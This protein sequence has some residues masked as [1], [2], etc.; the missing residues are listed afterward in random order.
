MWISEYFFLF[1]S[2]WL[3]SQTCKYVLKLL[4]LKSFRAKDLYHTYVYASGM[5]STHAAVLSSSL[6]FLG[7]TLGLDNPI[8]F[9]FAAFGIFWLYEIHLQRERFK[10]IARLLPKAK[11][12]DLALLRD[13]QGHDLS[14][15]IGGV[16]LGTLIYFFPSR[17][18]LA[19]GI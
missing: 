3:V 1:A 17:F 4:Q 14:D 12:K 5:P 10:V 8:T 18:L 6:L 19:R 15:L 9:V 13:I 11:K 2:T 16:L 7:N